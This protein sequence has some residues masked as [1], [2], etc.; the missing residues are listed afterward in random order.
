MQWKKNISIKTSL[1]SS[2]L[3]LGSLL[4]VN[5]LFTIINVYQPQVTR[6]DGLFRSNLLADYI[7]LATTEEAKER[8]FSVSYISNIAHDKSPDAGL[9]VKIDE[10]RQAGDKNVQLA[11]KLAKELVDENWAGD[12][13]K[14]AFQHTQTEWQ[15]LQLLRQRVDN[16]TSLTASELLIQMNQFITTFS[17]LRQMAFN[18]ASHLEGAIFNNILIKQA[19]WEA[20]EYAGRERAI[21]AAAISASEPMSRIKIQTLGKYR[22][23]VESKL[24]YLENIALLLITNEKHHMYAEEVNNYWNQIKKIFLGEFQKTRELVYIS[25]ETGQYTISASDWLAQSTR[26]INTISNFN[27]QISLDAGRH[28][29]LFGSVA[30]S[31]YWKAT[32]VAI[33]SI[34]LIGL[35]L[36][37]INNIIQQITAFKEVIVKVADDKDITLRVDDSGNN[38]LSI[39][40]RS[41]NILI[42]NLQDMISKI[43]EASEKVDIDVENSV[44]SCRDNSLGIS[45]QEVDVE[46]LASAMTE[47]VSSIQSIGDSSQTNAQSS[48]KV[49]DEI[50]L[51][52]KIMR[53]TATS[54]QGLG[55]MIEQSS[56]VIGLLATDSLNIGQVLDVIKGI[57]EQTNL[58]ALNAAIEAARAGDQ[59]RGFAVVADEV[60]TLA[61]RTHESTQEIHQMIERLQSQ[62]QKATQ[63][64]QTSLEESRLAISH[65]TS[66][67]ETL[68]KVILSMG[69]I[70]QMNSH[71]ADATEQ[72]GIVAGEINQNV[73]SLQ[74]IAESNH[75]L[76]QDSVQNMGNISSEMKTLIDIVLQYKSAA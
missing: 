8:G 28:A 17:T 72:Q 55:T 76:A 41:F 13:F 24:S 60:R 44:Q 39:L 51:S 69:Q 1:F 3:I 73:N 12:E 16:D 29:N 66:A 52:G 33:I 45:Q 54:I 4:I 75:Q 48:L 63:A 34:A 62:S 7:I 31:N 25:A 71:I 58:L 23:L 65:V 32:I 56:D 9:K 67:D 61:G 47:M 40:S 35:G 37:M 74:T 53:D 22:G 14:K 64:M 15:Q 18:P 49:N 43:T 21:V 50:K 10:F 46:Q 6:S 36:L 30:R 20:S 5:L 42:Q 11:L 38:E 68:N 57:A 19:I 2:M 26:A 27:E 70:M 59:G